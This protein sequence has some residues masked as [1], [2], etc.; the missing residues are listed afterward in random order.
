MCG[1][2]EGSQSRSAAPPDRL[3]RSIYQR[4]VTNLDERPFLP[5]RHPERSRFSGG[6]KDLARKSDRWSTLPPLVVIQACT[7]ARRLGPAS[8]ICSGHSAIISLKFSMKRAAR[9]SYLR[10]YSSRL[11]QVLA[12]SRICEGTPSH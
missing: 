12:G 10:K 6:A 8:R 1:V 3:G 5:G 4:L 2:S 7:V 11:G 9:A